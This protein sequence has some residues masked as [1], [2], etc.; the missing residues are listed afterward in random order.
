MISAAG[1]VTGETAGG[2]DV[3]LSS[4]VNSICMVISI[5]IIVSLLLVM[6]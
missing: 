1:I 4:A 3:G 2:G 5:A 6:L